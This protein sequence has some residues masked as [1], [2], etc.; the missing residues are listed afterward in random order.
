MAQGARHFSQL[1]AGVVDAGLA[2]PGDARNPR[3]IAALAGARLVYLL[4]GDPGHLRDCLAGEDVRAAL[5]T[6]LAAGGALAG[7]SA[8]AMVLGGQVLLRS[9]DPRPGSRHSRDGL[10]ILPAT[11][12]PHAEKSLEGWLPAA[13]REG[14]GHD[15]LALDEQTGVVFKGG[16]WLVLGRGRARWLPAGEDKGD[17]VP[18]GSGIQ[19][20]LPHLL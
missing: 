16:S 8:G 13:R 11:V 14:P 20:A 15:V 1:D 7:S 19:I 4:G 2:R 17:P 3:V 12:I 18:A 9:R 5:R 6:V 10:G